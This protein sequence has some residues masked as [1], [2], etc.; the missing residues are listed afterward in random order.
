M[1]DDVY[2]M[3]GSAIINEALGRYIYLC[4]KVIV[5]KFKLSHRC[6]KFF[7][8]DFLGGGGIAPT[9]K[10][11][12]NSY[13]RSYFDINL[14]HPED[15]YINLVKVVLSQAGYQKS[16]SKSPIKKLF[17]DPANFMKF[18]L[19]D[20]VPVLTTRKLNYPIII[21]ELL[22]LI[23][24]KTNSKE[25]D[26]DASGE[27]SVYWKEATSSEVLQAKN[28]QYAEGDMGPIV[29]F[30]WRHWGAEYKGCDENYNGRGEDQLKSLIETL[31]SDP[32]SDSLLLS[33][34]NVADLKKMV[35]SPKHSSIQFEVIG[36]A[37]LDALLYFNSAD[38]VVELPHYVAM[39]SMLVNI[40][41]HLTSLKPGF[42]KV[43]IG[44]AYIHHPNE[45]NMEKLIKR[46]PLPFPKLVF[47]RKHELKVVD[48]FAV[49]HFELQNYES[50]D[51]MSFK[52]I[53]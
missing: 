34:W 27:G 19:E 16:G 53:V 1:Y 46:T 37:K 44:K 23:S 45:E 8:K 42:L 36:D 35:H 4:K 43:V 39:Y 24:G 6:D 50:W 48:D 26:A 14:R 40:V 11:S 12:T 32:Y 41:A 49:S 25:I 17:G 9:K 51:R 29:G 52:V 2:I 38:V 18:D 47:K 5:T 3:G 30:Q 28:L 10:E 20:S 31:R 33:A 7:P 22:L 13:D 15:Q 21:R